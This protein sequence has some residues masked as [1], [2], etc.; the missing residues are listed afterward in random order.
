MPVQF[1]SD[2][3]LLAFAAFLVACA[4]ALVMHGDIKWEVAAAFITGSLAIPGL[5][6]KKADL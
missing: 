5:L 4:V 2:P 6:G 3:K 1:K